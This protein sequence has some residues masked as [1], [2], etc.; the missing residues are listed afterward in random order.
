MAIGPLGRARRPG[1]ASGQAPA[2]RDPPLLGRG[3]VADEDEALEAG[4]DRAGV[5]G[6]HLQ[7]LADRKLGGA[8]G[9]GEPAVLLGERGDRD[10]RPAANRAEALEDADPVD[11]AVEGQRLGAGVGDRPL[12]ARR[13]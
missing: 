10:V 12:G 1:R 5:V 8:V 13:G 9:E 3:P 7:A 2:R 11:A 4:D 6:D